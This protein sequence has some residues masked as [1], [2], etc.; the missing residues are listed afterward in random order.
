MDVIDLPRTAYGRLLAA[1]NEAHAKAGAVTVR[2]LGAD[3]G[4]W[5]LATEDDM[6]G[7]GTLNISGDIVVF[8]DSTTLGRHEG[9][10]AWRG[11]HETPGGDR[12]ERF[13]LDGTAMTLSWTASRA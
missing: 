2:V 10:V 6:G 8:R 13:T 7:D 9:L 4:E 11:G 1:L 3:A 12:I 5:I